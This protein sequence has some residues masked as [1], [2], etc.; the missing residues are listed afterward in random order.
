MYGEWRYS[1]TILDLGTR[2]R[3]VVSFSPGNFTPR[4]GAPGT[5]WKGGWVGPRAGLHAV[6]KSFAL[7]GNGTSAVQPVGRPYTDWAISAHTSWNSYRLKRPPLWSSAQSFRL[8]F[9]SLPYQIFWEVRGLQRGPPSLVRT[10]EELLE[11]KS[12]GSG[13]ENRD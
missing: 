5:H 9:D 3:W 4:E 7:V 6:L 10:I 2:W 12:S 11:W 1:F 8:G 13:L